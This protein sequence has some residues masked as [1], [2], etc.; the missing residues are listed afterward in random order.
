MP[1]VARIAPSGYIYHLLTRGNN[2]QDIFKAEED[3]G[4]YIDIV[5]SYK[6]NYLFTLYHYA[7]MANYVHFVLETTED[8]ASLAEVMKGINLILCAILQ[9]N[10]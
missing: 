9:E 10:L 8:G 5:R 2:G 7:L 1:R 4:K 3:Y 6:E